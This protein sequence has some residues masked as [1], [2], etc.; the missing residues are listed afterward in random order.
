MVEFA[1]EFRVAVREERVVLPAKVAAIRTGTAK[2]LAVAGQRRQEHGA[3]EVA[4]ADSEVLADGRNAGVVGP[5]CEIVLAVIA[6]VESR[7]DGV[8]IMA[9]VAMRH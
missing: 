8:G 9:V 3:R 7:Q 4:R 1:R 5:L 2:S 6:A